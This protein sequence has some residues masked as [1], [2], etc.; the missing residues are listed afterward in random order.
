[1]S[2]VELM[3]VLLVLSVVCLFLFQQY[4]VCSKDV[5][6]R[7]LAFEQ[8]KVKVERE[9]GL[10]E[11]SCERL[12]ESIAELEKRILLLEQAIQEGG[13]RLPAATSNGEQ[14]C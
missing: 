14:E 8:K 9:I 4:D 5:A 10:Q 6:A 3:I 13:G 2:G 12:G 7:R 11:Q 1:M